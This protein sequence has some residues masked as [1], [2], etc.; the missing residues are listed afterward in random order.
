MHA[1]T[2]TNNPRKMR[3]LE[4]LGVHVT[5]RIPCIVQPQEHSAG[6]LATKQV[7]AHV[8]PAS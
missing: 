3:V 6:Y 5:A 2:Q 7:G 8:W 4:E 1:P